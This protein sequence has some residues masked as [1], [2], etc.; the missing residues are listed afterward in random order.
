MLR[1]GRD[2]EAVA[3]WTKAGTGNLPLAQYYSRRNPICDRNLL[4]DPGVLRVIGDKVK[5][6][7]ATPWE[8]EYTSHDH[9]HKYTNKANIF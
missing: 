7:P 9:I 5:A 4:A 3:V 6:L 8:I 1:R 2:H